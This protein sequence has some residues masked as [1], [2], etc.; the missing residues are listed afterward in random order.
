MRLIVLAGV[1]AAGLIATGS[2]SA[3]VESDGGATKVTATT[4]AIELTGPGGT[5]SA[6]LALNPGGR[7]CYVIEVTLTTPGDVP[8]EPAPGIGSAHIHD[9]ATGGIA[10]PLDSVFTS[11]GGGTFVAS[12]CV[13]GDK[14]VVRDAIANP[15]EYYVNVHTTSFPGG[16]VSGTL[17]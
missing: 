15:D 14:D 6:F 1:L 12:D 16:A 11:V 4:F 9:V 13:R 7:V 3:R 5:G 17:A 8:R 2:A 10:V